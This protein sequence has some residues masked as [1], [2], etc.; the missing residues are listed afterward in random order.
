MDWP[1]TAR[2]QV[3]H[4]RRDDR[5][6][7]AGDLGGRRPVG[8]AWT[9]A[10]PTA[11]S[12]TWRSP[13][14]PRSATSPCTAATGSAPSSPPG[15]GS[16]GYPAHARPAGRRAAAALGRR[17]AAR[18]PADGR[19][20]LAA[21]LETLRRPPRRRGL[22]VVVSDFL[23]DQPTGSA[24]CA[25]CRPGTSC[26]RSRSSTRASWSCPTSGC[27]PSSTRRPGRRWRCRPATRSCARGSPR[28]R[29]RSG[30]QIAAGAAPGRGRRTC[31]CAPTGT[32]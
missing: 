20:D 6:P 1:V 29:P 14:S 27:S 7:R 23:G 4:V 25:G 32:G 12:A 22:V 11:R 13:G 18:P 24:R 10:P 9:S 30:P 31:S 5:R 3:P 28:A 17:D 26:W 15:S 21:A 8:R 19:G 16:T 2:T